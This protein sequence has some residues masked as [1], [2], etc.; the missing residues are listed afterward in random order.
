MNA[1][2]TTVKNRQSLILTVEMDEIIRLKA[3]RIDI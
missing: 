3:R 1:D 2:D